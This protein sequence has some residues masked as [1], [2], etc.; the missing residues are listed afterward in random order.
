MI[1]GTTPTYRFELPFEVALI[2]KLWITYAQF[3]SELFTLTEADC[4][5]NGNMVTVTLSQEQTLKL[6]ANSFAEIQFRVLMHDDTALASQI[7]T[8]HTHR[9]LKE[10]VIQ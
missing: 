1:R 2:K 8:D 7:I 9:V 5:M 4:E 10:G 6:N 3:E